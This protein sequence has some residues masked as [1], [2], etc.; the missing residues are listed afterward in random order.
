MVEYLSGKRNVVRSIPTC[1]SAA[2]FA[3]LLKSFQIIEKSSN[4]THNSF[5]VFTYSLSKLHIRRVFE[6]TSAPARSWLILPRFSEFSH[7]T[8]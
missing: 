7:E 6:Q 2:V 3:F 5:S 8:I 4:F 1:E